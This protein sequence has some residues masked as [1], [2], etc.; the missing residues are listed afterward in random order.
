M[1]EVSSHGISDVMEKLIVT[2][3]VMR[4]IVKISIF[5]PRRHHVFHFSILVAKILNV[6]Q[7]YVH[8]E[9]ARSKSVDRFWKRKNLEKPSSLI[10]IDCEL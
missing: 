10:L 5:E 6:A 8:W 9:F 2:M 7:T 1:T 4:S 3:E